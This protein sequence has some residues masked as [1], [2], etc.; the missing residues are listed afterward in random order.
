MKFRTVLLF[1]A[2]AILITG[3]KNTPKENQQQADAEETAMTDQTQTQDDTPQVNPWSQIGEEPVLR[4]ETTKGDITVKLYSDTPLHR[5]NFV[6]LAKSGFYNGILFHR[7]IKDFMIQVGDPNTKDPA[8]A[9]EIGKG[10]P[11]YTIP[12]E[13]VPGKTHKKGALAAARRGDSVNPAKESSGSQFY[14]VHSAANCSHLDGEYT[15]FGEVV[16]GLDVVDK[17]ANVAVGPK[18][19]PTEQVCIISITPVIAE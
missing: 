10:G 6:K 15:I 16:E 3:C 19:F 8:K 17:I 2:A 11:G 1:L 18:D 4:I 5:D 7:V 14:I 12:A 13:I 9:S